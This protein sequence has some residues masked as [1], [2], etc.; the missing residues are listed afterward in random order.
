MS[1]IEGGLLMK[2]INTKKQFKDYF[3]ACQYLI[4]L[5]DKF[6]CYHMKNRYDICK[7]EYCKLYKKDNK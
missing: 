2:S 4:A 7:K 1:H 6:F 5:P 3:P